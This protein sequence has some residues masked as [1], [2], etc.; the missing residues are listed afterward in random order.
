MSQKGGRRPAE[1]PTGASDG[2]SPIH[3]QNF[4]W[5]W[6][7]VIKTLVLLTLNPSEVTIRNILPRTRIGI[8]MTRKAGHYVKR[9]GDMICEEIALGSTLAEALQIVGYLA[10][11]EKVFWKWLN[12]NEEFRQ[13][14][15][16]ARQMQADKLADEHLS[17][18]RTVLKMD[19]K[20]APK[21]KVAAD[22]LKWQAEVRN[23]AKFG[24]KAE[25]LGKKDLKPDEIKAEIARL[26][27]ELGIAQG[28]TPS[29]PGKLHAVK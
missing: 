22:I 17:L 4:F 3:T 9:I 16:R 21:F 5:F 8:A 25:P 12:S 15:E 1:T 20:Q 13:Q 29:E 10:P 2:G 7:E 28:G 11:S 6:W 23:R 14:Y 19:G 27:K 18:S 26:E 24:P